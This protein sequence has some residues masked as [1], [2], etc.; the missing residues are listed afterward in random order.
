[1]KSNERQLGVLGEKESTCCSL[2]L[3]CILGAGIVYAQE[4]GYFIDLTGSNAHINT[5]IANSIVVENVTLSNGTLILN[6]NTDNVSSVIIIGI[7][8]TAA[9]PT[10]TAASYQPAVIVTYFGENKVPDGIVGFP[11]PWFDPYTNQAAPNYYY[12]WNITLVNI[13]TVNGLGVPIERAFQPLVTKYPQLATSCMAD[14]N[15]PYD[16]GNLTLRAD[17]VEFNGRLDKQCMVLFS[18][19]QLSAEE[20][21]NLTEDII[22]ELTPTIIEWYS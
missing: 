9:Q 18:Y 3:L 2:A 12:S 21:P 7:N 8:Y 13:N 20:I 4:A 1:M 14:P 6:I 11:N 15:Q 19:S 22:I 17:T 16:T 10:P 5:L